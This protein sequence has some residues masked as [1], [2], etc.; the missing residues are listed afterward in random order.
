MRGWSERN[1][2]VRAA[3]EVTRDGVVRRHRG[4]GVLGRPLAA[5]T[6]KLERLPHDLGGVARL[7][8]LVLPLARADAALDV[9]LAALG[10]VLSGQLGLLAPQHHPVPLR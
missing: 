9:H 1:V 6:E 2:V 5:C 7:A 4:C 3:A 8:L 10:E